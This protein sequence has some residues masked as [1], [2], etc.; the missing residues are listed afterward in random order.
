MIQGKSKTEDKKVKKKT[1]RPTKGD[2]AIKKKQVLTLAKELFNKKTK[3]EKEAFFNK[4]FD[5][6][7]EEKAES[8]I[9]KYKDIKGGLEKEK[10]ESEKKRKSLL[11][12][13]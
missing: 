1:T 13:I 4:I 6:S 8:V 5:L 2:Q 3:A 9:K 12:Q 10:A 11:A 7:G